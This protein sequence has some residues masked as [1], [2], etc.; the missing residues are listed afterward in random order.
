M[1]TTKLD[2]RSNGKTN[3][4]LLSLDYGFICGISKY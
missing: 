1:N 4:M 3:G 2:I